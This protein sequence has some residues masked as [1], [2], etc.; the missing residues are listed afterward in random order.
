MAFLVSHMPSFCLSRQDHAIDFPAGSDCLK[1]G[2]RRPK[3]KAGGRKAD[4]RR[5]KAG[6]RRP[7]WRPT[8]RSEV[9]GVVA[10][11]Q[12]RLAAIMVMTGRDF[13][14]AVAVLHAF[15][16]ASLALQ[17]TKVPGACVLVVFFFAFLVLL[18]FFGCGRQRETRFVFFCVAP[19]VACGR[20]PHMQ[21]GTSLFAVVVLRAFDVAS[22]PL[23]HQKARRGSVARA[24]TS[25]GQSGG[26]S[27]G[28]AQR[29][30]CG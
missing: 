8:W 24:V 14:L 29:L 20:R 17:H 22:L 5:S 11:S 7:K 18:R 2:G 1:A 30:L 23:H 13:S 10:L 12:S 19:Q 28:R 15:D 6:G 27:L 9:I 16:M 21:I 25:K 3:A 4:G 26:L